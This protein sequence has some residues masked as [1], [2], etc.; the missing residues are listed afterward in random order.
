MSL[1]RQASNAIESA[2]GSVDLGNEVT[3]AINSKL[4][5]SANGVINSVDVSLTSAQIK[6][7]LTTPI[8]LIA[9]PGAGLSIQVVQVF[10]SLTFNSIA[11]AATGGDVME[12]RY[13]NGSGT[14]LASVSQSILISASSTSE[15]SNGV[16]PI[17]P[18]D[19]APVVVRMAHNPTLGNSPI[20]VRVYYRTLSTLL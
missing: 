1:S 18:V 17:V 9:A 8:T 11:Y 10:A 2:M 5:A 4:E 13:T 3:N 20:I 15:Y 14:Q 16:S 12:V 19:N 7:L 6:L